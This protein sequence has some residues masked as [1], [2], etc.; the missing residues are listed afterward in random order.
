L[1]LNRYINYDY[2]SIYK[3][4]GNRASEDRLSERH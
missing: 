2:R 1:L 4:I 3:N